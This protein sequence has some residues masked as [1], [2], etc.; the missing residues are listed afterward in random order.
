M[1]NSIKR[2]LVPVDFSAM[3][4]AAL[5]HA[6]EL[7]A[8]L[9]ASIELLHVLE[10]PPAH[11]MASEAYVPLPLEYRQEVRRHAERHLDDPVRASGRP[12]ATS[13][14]K[15]SR[16]RRSRRTPGTTPST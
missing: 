7:A 3:S 16:S 1:A 9:G 12:S 4:R 14:V 11:V 8:A 2:I 15:E 13:C 5:W 6:G 10:L